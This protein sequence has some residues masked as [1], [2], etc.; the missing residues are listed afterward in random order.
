LVLALGALGCAAPVVQPN[1]T[2][3]PVPTASPSGQPTLRTPGPFDIG[4][5]PINTTEIATVVFVVD[6]DTIRV[7]MANDEF[8]EYAVRYIGID[9]P[10]R[11]AEPLWEEATEANADLIEGR[12]VFMEADISDTDQ[13]GRL[14]RHVWLP[15]DDGWLNIGAEIVRL[16]LADAK[17][18]QPDTLWDADYAAAESE[19]RAADLGIWAQTPNGDS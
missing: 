3:S 5:G 12:E 14:L 1:R 10:E 18:Y 15:T 2:P 4:M 19:A 6:G 11:E 16:G 17:T 13:H 7:Q 9:A 8:N